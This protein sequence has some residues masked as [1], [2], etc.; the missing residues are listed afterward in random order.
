MGPDFLNNGSVLFP[1]S[2]AVD[3]IGKALELFE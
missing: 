2:A 1:Q 3:E